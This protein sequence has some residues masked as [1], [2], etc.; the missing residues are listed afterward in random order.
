VP[1]AVHCTC[2][3]AANKKAQNDHRILAPILY[4]TGSTHHIFT[5]RKRFTK[6]N[7]RV[8]IVIKTGGGPV[9]P[10]GVGTVQIHVQRSKNPNDFEL[11]TLNGV[12]FVPKFDINI[13]SSLL[14][15]SSGGTLIK[16]SLYNS[17]RRCWGQL[18]TEKHGFFLNVKEHFLPRVGRK[19][20]F[21]SSCHA[22]AEKVND[23]MVKISTVPP[24]N[25]EEYAR[26]DSDSEE[27]MNQAKERSSIND[28]R[29]ATPSYKKKLVQGGTMPKFSAENPE[30]SREVRPR[31]PGKTLDKSL[32]EPIPGDTNSLK[33]RGS[34]ARIPLPEPPLVGD[35]EAA[36]T[37]VE[38][39]PRSLQ[40][41]SSGWISAEGDLVVGGDEELAL[42][43][44]LW[45]RRLGHI[46]FALLKKTAKV[47]SGLPDFNKILGLQYVI[48]TKTVAV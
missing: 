3:N 27:N 45:H 11:V 18:N 33:Q 34:H 36:P 32:K 17:N 26:F 29:N 20:P 24:K 43:V 21:S 22:A 15:Y 38:H 7:R 39:S 30:D 31:R 10:R 44:L 35:L 12:L 8:K 40:R 48:C 37:A 25:R 47:T 46:G 6:F 14:H 9:I 5:S 1:A 13:I 42:K 28:T 4:D 2:R 19:N 23:L 41:T 16:E